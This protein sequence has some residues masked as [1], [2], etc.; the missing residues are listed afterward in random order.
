MLR[1]AMARSS[2]SC[3]DDVDAAPVPNHQTGLDNA[4]DQTRHA[5]RR[6][7]C[8]STSGTWAMSAAMVG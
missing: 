1:A 6:R 7:F 8:M 3:Q 4:V 5:A 2:T